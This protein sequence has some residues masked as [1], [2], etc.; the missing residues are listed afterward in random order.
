MQPKD[1]VTQ[2]GAVMSHLTAPVRGKSAPPVALPKEGAPVFT[3]FP[4]VVPPIGGVP[5]TSVVV[6]PK[7]KSCLI[8]KAKSPGPVGVNRP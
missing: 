1:A 4:P 8:C 3:V 7:P 5:V 2:A 6:Y